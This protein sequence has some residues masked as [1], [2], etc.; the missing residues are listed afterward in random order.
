MD[1]NEAIQ[2]LSM[3]YNITT[4]QTKKRQALEKAIKALDFV[5]AVNECVN[6]HQFPEYLEDDII[7]LVERYYNE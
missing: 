2:V 7:T 4:L 6:K 3:L 5:E 1:N